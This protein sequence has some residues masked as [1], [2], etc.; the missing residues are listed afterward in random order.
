M[1]EG[2]DAKALEIF[3]DLY[4]FLENKIKLLPLDNPQ[5]QRLEDIQQMAASERRLIEE[6][7]TPCR[8]ILEHLS[9]QQAREVTLGVETDNFKTKAPVSGILI[10]EW[11]KVQIKLGS[12][13]VAWR[14]AGSQYY[15]YPDKVEIR[16]LD[17]RRSGFQLFF[18]LPFKSSP[19]LLQRYPDL[20]Q[21]EQVGYW[22]EDLS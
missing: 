8:F 21:H 2:F 15:F 4:Y 16:P 17:E 13:N 18:A 11:G 22:H 7:S 9:E 3:E 1:A 20:K 12:V 6:V 10:G 19:G 14:D 5:R